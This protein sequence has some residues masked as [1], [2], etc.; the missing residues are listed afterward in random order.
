MG[1]N[2]NWNLYTLR[3]N[4]LFKFYVALAWWWSIWPKLVATNGVKKH[5]CAWMNTFVIYYCISIYNKTG[6]PLQ[7][8]YI[9]F[10]D[11][12]MLYGINIF[13]SFALSYIISWNCHTKQGLEDYTNTAIRRD[14]R[15]ASNT[16]SKLYVRVTVHLWKVNKC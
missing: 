14:T 1:S 7:K 5:C 11:Q 6:C 13:L 4:S 9:F 2:T 10:I 15:N 3:V 12:F 16:Y 8:K